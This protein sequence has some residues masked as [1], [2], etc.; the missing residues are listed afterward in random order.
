MKGVLLMMLAAN[1]ALGQ[2]QIQEVCYDP[3]GTDTAAEWVEL[4]NSGGAAQNLEGWLVDLSG[5][6][7]ELPPLELEAGETLVIHSNAVAGSGPDGL[8]IWFEGDNMG[9]THGFVG[10]WSPGGQLT[11]NLVDYMEYGTAGHSW[12]AQAV[13]KEIWPAGEFLPDVESGHSLLRKDQGQGPASWMDEAS[14]VPGTGETTVGA[15]ETPLPA[16]ARISGVWPNPFNPSTQVEVELAEISSV[17]LSVYNLLGRNVARVSEERMAAG[18]HQ[19]EFNLEG[20]SSGPY[21]VELRAG[22]SR[23]TRKILLLR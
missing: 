3:E 5:P 7:L 18:R 17:E 8:E 19:I 4:V 13:D 12:E 21:L 1:A 16:S 22:E 15:V 14:P 2:I 6:N 23:D 20:L 11:E 9:N 10:L